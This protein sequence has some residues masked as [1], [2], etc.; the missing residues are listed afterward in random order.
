[1]SASGQRPIP[2]IYMR[3]GTSRGPYFDLEDLPKDVATRNRV[4]LAV[5]GS[6]DPRQIDGLGG[7]DPLTSKVAMVQR[8]RRPGVDVDYLF[9]QVSIENAIVDTE[10]SCGNMLAGVG[11]FAI[12]RNLIAAQDPETRLTVF[13]VN[14]QSRIEAIIRT[15]GGRV[16]YAGDQEICGVPGTAAPVILNFIDVVG[17]KTG[18][19]L[20]TGRPAEEIDGVPVSCVDAAM[21]MV[22]IEA[23]A[24]GLSGYETDAL[25]EPQFLRRLE[26]LRLEAGRRMGLG[27]VRG[28]VIP[29]LSLLARPRF[30][31]TITSRYFTPDRLHK[32][33]SVTGAICVGSSTL[34]RGS[35]AETLTAPAPDGRVK[36]EHPSG[37]IEVQLA[38]DGKAAAPEVHRAG[39]VR[40][41]RKIMEG[42]V[43]V[44]A[45]IWPANTP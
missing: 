33:H 39:I 28:K 14:T 15:P 11:P 42:H 19:L 4:L 1:M 31:G 7:A 27:D 8:S 13:N 21:P 25:E 16:E 2:C 40:T 3:G 30:G 20:P 29:K 24:L 18:S 45:D 22:L 23:A 32:A 12:E 44:P 41:A 38:A 34:I 5:M 9:A 35:V 26:R 37:W 43:F 36:I 6:P 10:P 17:A